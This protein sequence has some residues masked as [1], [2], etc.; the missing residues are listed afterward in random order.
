MSR[1]QRMKTHRPGGV[2]RLLC[3]GAFLAALLALALAGCESDDLVTDATP[4]SGAPDSGGGP[5][6]DVRAPGSTDTLEPGPDTR[7]PGPDGQSPGDDTQGPGDDT[8]GP[9]D[10]AQGPGDD[11][12]DPGDD[13]QGPPPTGWPAG[14]TLVELDA[15]G[16]ATLADEDFAGAPELSD[17]DLEWAHGPGAGCWEDWTLEYIDGRHHRAFALA[18]PVAGNTVLT[19]TATPAGQA[20]VSLYVYRVPVG[21]YPVPPAVEDVGFCLASLSTDFGGNPG[22][23]ETVEMSNVGGVAHNVFIGVLGAPGDAFDLSV[24]VTPAADL[25]YDAVG[26]HESFPDWVD[27][28]A[29]GQGATVVRGDLAQGAPVC[30]LDFAWSSQVACFPEPVRRY[31]DGNTVFYAVDLPRESALTVT[32]VP[33]PGVE[34]SLYAVQMGTTSFYV[35]PYVPVATTCEASHGPNAYGDGTVEHP[36]NPGQPESVFLN[37]RAN[38]YHV[39]V[40]VSGDDLTGT[41][42]G[43]SLTF[44]LVSWDGNTCEPDDYRSY[45]GW[46]AF[47]EEVAVDADGQARRTGDLADGAP[48]CTLEWASTSQVACFPATDDAYFQ[49]N[50]VFYALAEPVPPH[51]A[52]SVVV[53]PE[54]GV[55]VSLYGYWM[56]SQSYYLPPLLP[57]AGACE[58]SYA[59]RLDKAP[60]PGVA[61][62]ITFRNPTD[63]VYNYVFAVAGHEQGGTSGG[64]TVD[65][66]LVEAPGS[67]C[68]ESLPGAT[69][70]AW[71]GTVEQVAVDGEGSATVAGDLA[72][73]ACTDVSFASASQVACFP[74]TQFG[75]FLGNHVFYALAEPIPPRSIV[76]ITVRPAA[77]VE[78]SLYGYQI[79]ATN[80]YVPPAVPTAVSCEGSY[81]TD[82]SGANPG[83][84]E[85]IHFENPSDTHSYNIFFAVAGDGETGTQ[86]A[87]TVDVR[88]ETGQ[89]HCEESLPGETYASWPGGVTQVTFDADDEA[90]LSGDLSDGACTALGFADE[91][92]VACFPATYG[93]FFGGNQVFYALAEPLPPRSYVIIT[94]E[95][96]AG[97]EVSL[98]GYQSGE[99]S[100]PVPPAVTSVVSCE[101]SYSRD[102]WHEPNPGEA[103]TIAFYNPSNGQSY[104]VFFAVA[105]GAEDGTAGAYTVRAAIAR[106]VAHCPESLPGQRYDAWPSSV[107]Q[108]HLAAG[109]STD[110]RGDLADGACL[111]LGWADDSS[112]ACFPET[113]NTN[114]QGNVVFYA[115]DDL[116]PADRMLRATVTPDAGVDAS[117]FVYLAG[118]DEY[119]VPPYVPPVPNCEASYDGGPGG[120]ESI[121]IHNRAGAHR[122]FIGVGGPAGETNGGFTLSLENAPAP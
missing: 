19:V 79:A 30:S 46:P 5:G 52:L 45:E 118:P 102:L 114:F 71:P 80:F 87:Y 110:V 76:D 60:D 27:E 66:Q 42:G 73:G 2:R 35:P 107:E 72:D 94:A 3:A 36:P 25:C 18:E 6:D 22:V 92:D 10:D 67:H 78:V 56:G 29:I 99:T 15:A 104:N 88:L 86:G 14:V 24:T 120:E 97:V 112:V 9:G 62:V 98:Y 93:H 32:A 23:A 13:T 58:A 20:D 70:P 51:S 50:H 83:E 77:G 55:E 4:G 74:A 82:I 37:S 11:A 68:P 38:P 43:F 54:P 108:V 91:S 17:A 33:D 121:E 113:Q 1:Q 122:V 69:Y 81:E 100:F 28:V 105:G 117:L 26:A 75:H 119:F 95:P 21:E 84:P 101:A 47:V 12:Q 7:D 85:T 31:F 115:L 48:L 89:V 64:F 111:S 103:E 53:T 8:Q 57:S 90:V 106:S 40:A 16:R 44:D 61:E 49:G 41:A 59:E 63:N 109:S 116:L 34:V 96:E 39:L 65:V